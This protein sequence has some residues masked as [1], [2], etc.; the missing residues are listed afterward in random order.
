[1]KLNAKF[2]SAIAIVGL[3]ATTLVGIPFS[4]QA[5]ATTEPAFP[6]LHERLEELAEE[7]ELTDYQRSQ[8][9]QL[10]EDRRVELEA[11]I[12]PEQ[13]E[14]FRQAIANGERFRDAIQAINLSEQ[15]RQDIRNLFESSRE[16]ARD[17][18]TP[19]QQEELQEIIQSRLGGRRFRRQ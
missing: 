2:A 16:E 1:M 18:L 15:Q 17:I 9:Q 11:I 6:A 3:T 19:A 8:F 12:M 10:R 4:A 14:A 5:Q 7:L 13:Q